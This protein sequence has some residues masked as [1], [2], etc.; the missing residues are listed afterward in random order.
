MTPNSVVGLRDRLH[1]FEDR[2]VE[3]GERLAAVEVALREGLENIYRRMDREGV[4][5]TNL[6]Q[7]LKEWREGQVKRQEIQAKVCAEHQQRTSVVERSLAERLAEVEKERIDKERA[8]FWPR[9]RNVLIERVA[10]IIATGV[11]LLILTAILRWDI[12][13]S[14][15]SAL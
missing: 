8:A 15:L 6:A 1:R 3:H 2:A 10:G 9:F 11:I 14:L 13:K 7:E 5:G 12:I 4:I